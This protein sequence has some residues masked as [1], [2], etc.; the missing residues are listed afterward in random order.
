MKIIISGG[1]TGGHIYPALTLINKIKQN[2]HDCEFL[3]IG[4]DC[5]MES[6]IVPKA[7]IAFKTI[8]VQG[9]RRAL[10]VKN[11]KIMLKSFNSIF[12]S[13]QII[14]EFK[15]DVVVGTGGYVCGP[16]LLAAA[17]MKVPTLIQEQN[18]IPG[19]T[20]KILGKFVDAVA[21]GYQEAKQY[22]SAKKVFFTGNPIRDEIMTAQKSVA[23]KELGLKEDKFT[24]VISGGSRGAR[25]I[26]FA[27]LGV[28]KYFANNKKIQLLHITGKGDYNT[29]VD[30]LKID[31]KIDEIDNIVIK[32]YLYE[33]PLGVASA[34]L[35]IFR[36]GALGIAELMARAVPAILIPYP[37]AAENHQEYNAKVIENSGAGIVVKDNEVT[38][39][40]LIGIIESLFNDQESLLVM[41]QACVKIG[42]PNSSQL[43][44][45]LII[46]LA[47]KERFSC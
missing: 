42:K 23:L 20:N 38:S 18:V 11:I 33:M 30:K 31:L 16:V 41:K 47:K 24:V 5:G 15:P 36:A 26:N 45:D 35:G 46:K 27:M 3:Y 28:H 10:T 32:P 6:D 29:I 4:T 34:D 13:Y 17:L 21:V 44:A 40:K 8:D 43:I 22:F 1:G 25:S 7:G 9:F 14:K 12:K 37:Y 39:G 2:V 19:I